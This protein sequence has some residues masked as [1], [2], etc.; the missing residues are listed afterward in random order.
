MSKLVNV[1]RETG[2]GRPPQVGDMM[3]GWIP[4]GFNI[5]WAW[6]VVTSVTPI[7]TRGSAT[8]KNIEVKVEGYCLGLK[9]ASPPI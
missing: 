8:Q 7:L 1:T 4:A 9:R 6:W 3:S 2:Q 5:K